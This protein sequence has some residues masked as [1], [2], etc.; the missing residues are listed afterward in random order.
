MQLA[1]PRRTQERTGT[2]STT[3]GSARQAGEGRSPAT[4]GLA[5]MP[6]RRCLPACPSRP[7]HFAGE[8]LM[9]EGMTPVG[10]GLKRSGN[11]CDLCY[12][13]C[14]SNLAVSSGSAVLKRERQR[15]DQDRSGS[16]GLQRKRPSNCQGEDGRAPGLA[17]GLATETGRT[18][19]GRADSSGSPRPLTSTGAGRADANCGQHRPLKVETRFESRWGCS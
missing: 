6:A 13:A 14:Y 2:R 1:G 7:S 10:T 9:G 11:R 8:R 5:A 17:T 16:S 18:R 12:S 4:A 15:S 19:P 3:S